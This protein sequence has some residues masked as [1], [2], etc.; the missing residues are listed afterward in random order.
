MTTTMLPKV[1]LIS[2]PCFLQPMMRGSGHN[3]LS[4]ITPLHLQPQ[5]YFLGIFPFLT[6][7]QLFPVIID[8]GATISITPFQEHFLL[9]PIP[10]DRAVFQGVPKGLMIKGLGGVKSTMPSPNG[11]PIS[12]Q[13]QAYYIPKAN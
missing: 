10:T 8:S 1:L 11:N 3:K 5:D 6:W 4:L 12:F 9:T 7:F 2:C 13:A